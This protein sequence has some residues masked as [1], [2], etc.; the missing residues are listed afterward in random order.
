MNSSQKGGVAWQS[1]LVKFVDDP[2]TA[3]HITTFSSFVHFRTWISMS[4]KC[5]LCTV[6]LEVRS[7]RVSVFQNAKA[8]RLCSR[9]EK[10]D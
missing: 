5:S 9:F 8:T 2:Q 4:V 6:R 10:N 7:W 3:K 1:R